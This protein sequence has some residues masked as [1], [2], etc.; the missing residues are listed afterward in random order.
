MK[1]ILLITF[2]TILSITAY[3][4]D[5]SKAGSVGAQFL[6]IGVG[7]RYH[8]MG[9]AS[10]ASVDDIYSLYWNPAGMT[11]INS[12]Q[13]AITHINYLLDINL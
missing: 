13:L 10:V 4:D 9:E 1:K 7:A 11:N 8:G 6:K 3:A 2:I 12:S 5:F